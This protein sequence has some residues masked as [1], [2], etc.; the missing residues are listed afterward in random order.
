[1]G[2]IITRTH[3][4]NQPVME[5]VDNN[6]ALDRKI[7]Q[8]CSGLKPSFQWLLKELPRDEDKELIA[9]LIIAWPNDMSIDGQPMA[10]NTKVA[11]ID[12]LVRLARYH[13]HKKSFKEMTKEDIVDGYLRS[14]KKEFSQDI[15][16]K[17]VN[18]H[19]A[20]AAKYL[21]FWKWLT[22]RDLKKEE[23]QTPP[24]LKGYRAAKR[25]GGERTRVKREHH[26]T[27][28]EHVSFLKYCEDSRLACYHAIALE[29]G[30]RPSELLALKISD[31]QIKT[32]PS[33]GKKYAEFTIGDKVGGKM[34]KSRPTHISDAIPYFKVWVSVHPMRDS[35]QGAYLFPS[36]QNK[37]KYRNKPLEENSLRLLYDRTIEEHFPKLLQRPDISLED[38]AVLKSLIYDKPHHPY[39]RRHEFST[40]HGPKLSRTA[41]NQLLGHSPRSNLQDIYIQAAGNE[42]N[43]ELQIAKG[44]ITREETL[45]PA[46]MELMHPKYCPVCN[47]ANKHNADFCFKCNWVI[48]KKGVQEVR[49]KDEAAMIETEESKKKLQVLE[50]KQEILQANTASVLRALMATEMGAKPQQVEIIAWNAKEEGGSEG[51]FKAAAMARARNEA[52]ENE[53]Q[54]RYHNHQ[55]HHHNNNNN[56][57]SPSK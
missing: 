18:T 48:S 39:L 43:R 32:S 54:Q 37:A 5:F 25:K 46:Q 41:F 30:G 51:L 49:E 47:E 56:N 1:V 53:H 19:N 36:M 31:L 8:A 28:E 12:A 38:K 34:K 11:Y 26:W 33:T 52:R 22:Q 9:D 45:S 15:E 4:P 3:K 42:G 57:N 29:T 21:V 55:Q 23:R 6:F 2:K 40:E 17:W 14:L 44:I 24:Q 50:A 20:R 10:P 13:G 16:Q 35:P 7:K 27:A